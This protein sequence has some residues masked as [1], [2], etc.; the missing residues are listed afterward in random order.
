MPHQA[1]YFAVTLPRWPQYANVAA[2]AVR[3]AEPADDKAGTAGFAYRVF[4]TYVDVQRLVGRGLAQPWFQVIQQ[5]CHG[6]GMV[7]LRK[8][9][10]RKKI[11]DAAHIQLVADGRQ[12]QVLGEFHQAVHGAADS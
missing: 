5:A 6:L 3:R 10:L 2:V 8:L 11:A 4:R 12:A 7:A 9:W 1:H